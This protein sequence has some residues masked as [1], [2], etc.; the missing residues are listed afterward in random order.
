[1][2]TTLSNHITPDSLKRM[3]DNPAGDNI[4]DA[5]RNGRDK[6]RDTEKGDDIFQSNTGTAE[7][8]DEPTHAAGTYISPH[9]LTTISGNTGIDSIIN[10][11]PSD[12]QSGSDDAND[13]PDDTPPKPTLQT[14]PRELRDLIYDFVAANEERIV[15]GRRMLDT[16]RENSTWT[17]DQCFDHAV[18]LHPLSM[19]CGQFLDE[20]QVLHLAALGP[21]WILLVNNF[22]LEQVQIFSDYI[23]SEEF[24][25]VVDRGSFCDRVVDEIPEYNVEARLR[26]Q[27]DQDALRSAATLCQHVYF[28]KSHEGAAPQSLTDANAEEPWFGLAEV[29]SKY[30]PRTTVA[31]ASRRSMTFDEASQIRMLFKNLGE[32]IMDMPNY[33]YAGTDGQL[34]EVTLSF[35]YME[36]CWFNPFYDA[37]SPM[38]DTEVDRLCSRGSRR[39]DAT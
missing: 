30:T 22:D 6:R 35:A 10:C 17:L 28:D 15:L 12:K 33:D 34:G 1:M 27:M 4:P 25:Q 5:E 31:E 38:I 37:F 2:D 14:L 24:I 19:T 11:F 18:A 8:T 26:F 9:V 3:R 7:G 20:F 32:N 23:Q 13:A 36:Q 21:P 39:F 29:A 16:H